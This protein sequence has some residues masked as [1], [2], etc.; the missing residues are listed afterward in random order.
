MKNKYCE[1]CDS[2]F[3]ATVAYQIYC[4]AECRELATREKITARYV[5]K[6]RAKRKDK[7]RLCKSCSTIVSVYN[8]EQIC[9]QCSV[10]PTEVNRA[11]KE[12]RDLSNEDS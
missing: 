3:Q 9:N 11:L 2:V 7:P 1:W 5:L 4:S 12:I 10:N 6:R 8:D